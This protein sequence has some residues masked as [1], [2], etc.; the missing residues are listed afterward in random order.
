MLAMDRPSTPQTKRSKVQIVT[1]IKKE[2]TGESGSNNNTDSDNNSYGS[3]GNDN[4]DKSGGN[5]SNDK[6]NSPDNTKRNDNNSENESDEDSFTFDLNAFTENK[7]RDVT[8]ENSGD[9]VIKVKVTKKLKDKDGESFVFVM[10]DWNYW[11][12]KSNAMNETLRILFRHALPKH[13]EGRKLF[14]AAWSVQQREDAYSDKS[15]PKKSDNGFQSYVSI[16]KVNLLDFNIAT[17]V[18]VVNETI[19]KFIKSKKFKKCY[20]SCLR[21]LNKKGGLVNKIEEDDHDMWTLVKTVV[22]NEIY[23]ETMDSLVTDKEILKVASF[24]SGKSRKNAYYD[25]KIAN[26]MFKNASRKEF[27]F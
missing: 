26:V 1:P 14:G 7:V 13:H 15:K 2:K 20:L 3:N 22:F 18:Q 24:V 25:T 6:N 10:I 16:V 12:L 11:A 23:G 4:S 21:P 27:T 8:E 17:A 5:E 19:K 9:I